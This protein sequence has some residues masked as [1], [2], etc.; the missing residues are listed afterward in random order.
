MSLHEPFPDDNEPISELILNLDFNDEGEEEE[1][2]DLPP[3]Q[4]VGVNMESNTVPFP[5]P[6]WDMEQL[7]IPIFGNQ[8]VFF[9]CQMR[10]TRIC[11]SLLQCL[12]NKRSETYL[13]RIWTRMKPPPGV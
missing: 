13:S 5:D 11:S 9:W 7:P 3:Y 2:E 1:E 6:P 10:R 4:I 12:S 8:D